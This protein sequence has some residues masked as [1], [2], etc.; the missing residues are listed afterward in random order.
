MT[1]GVTRNKR[2][3]EKQGYHLVNGEPTTEE[4]A[5]YSTL[6]SVTVGEVSASSSAAR[7]DRQLQKM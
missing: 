4:R 3:V 7:T 6:A 2:H 5:R 1:N